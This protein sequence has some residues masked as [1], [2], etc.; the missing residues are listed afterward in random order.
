MH[1][2][3]QR[4]LAACDHILQLGVAEELMLQPFFVAFQVIGLLAKP[5]AEQ[6]HYAGSYWFTLG[7]YQVQMAWFPNT[8]SVSNRTTFERIASKIV[9]SKMPSGPHEGTTY[10]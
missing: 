6:A 7:P 1:S 4:T 10:R 2:Q 5:V 9:A 8:T 3:L